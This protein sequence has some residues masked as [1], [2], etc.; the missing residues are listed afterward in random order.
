[1]LCFNANK[2]GLSRRRSNDFWESPFYI[3]FTLVSSTDS[4]EPLSSERSDYTVL[5]S[6]SNGNPITSQKAAFILH[7]IQCSFS[8]I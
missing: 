7:E 3:N 2:Q 6:N 8:S 5:K 1:M 4:Y